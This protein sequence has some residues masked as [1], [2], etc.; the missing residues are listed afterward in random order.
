MVM[1]DQLK[2]QL[3]K[4]EGIRD[5][6]GQ[7]NIRKRFDKIVEDFD[8]DQPEEEIEK[9]VQCGYCRN[10]SA[11][12]QMSKKEIDSH[13]GKMFILKYFN[14]EQNTEKI[15]ESLFHIN[16]PGRAETVCPVGIK[17]EFAITELRK[18][19]FN[20]AIELE[21]YDAMRKALSN[22][23]DKSK[24]NIYGKRKE[25]K[26]NWLSEVEHRRSDYLYFVGSNDL[27]NNHDNV[28]R[29][30]WLLNKFKIP[31]TISKHEPDSGH[32]AY[33]FGDEATAEHYAQRV[34][35]LVQD[36]MFKK[37][38]VSCAHELNRL[39]KIF[40]GTKVEVMHILEMVDNKI[41]MLGSKKIH[42]IKARVAYLDTYHLCKHYPFSMPRDI[43]RNIGCEIVEK[44]HSRSESFGTGAGDGFDILFPHDAERIAE[45]HL[46]EAEAVK[47]D[48]LVTDDSYAFELL[49]K[50]AKKLGSKVKVMDLLSLV[51]KA[52]KW[53]L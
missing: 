45:A 17:H 28:R 46:N 6:L 48:Y 5:Q 32:I 22:L 14:N 18:K 4:I 42:K 25:L 19:F 8:V 50:T 37:V 35:N 24:E 3:N 16:M 27:L 30:L 31:Y 20:T 53:A 52:V 38:I 12:Y 2:K 10:T 40:E 34:S 21:Q 26:Y 49:S 29:V 51:V 43:L 36:M 9:C 39:K 23:K 44:T 13:S 41:S 11:T 1:K 47:A 15:I 33:M 7:I